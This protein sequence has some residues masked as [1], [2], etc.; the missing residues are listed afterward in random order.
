MKPGCV[1][2]S[3]SGSL[4]SITQMR[5]HDIAV[6]TTRCNTWTWQVVGASCRSNSYAKISY[7]R[8]EHQTCLATCSVEMSESNMPIAR[9]RKLL[10]I[11]DI[12]C[13]K[14][15]NYF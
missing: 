4:E 10:G 11:L 15:V 8:L 12:Q 6:L 13:K 9:S 1:S 2:S 7:R 3:S 14:N 5:V